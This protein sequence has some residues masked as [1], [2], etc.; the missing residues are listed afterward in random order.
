MKTK[1]LIR[2]LIFLVLVALLWLYSYLGLGMLVLAYFFFGNKI[3]F[4]ITLTIYLTV[5][6]LDQATKNRQ[7]G[8]CH[9]FGKNVIIPKEEDKREEVKYYTGKATDI[10]EGDNLLQIFDKVEKAEK[11][12]KKVSVTEGSSQMYQGAVN[13]VDKTG[14]RDD[15]VSDDD[16]SDY[17]YDE[18]LKTFD[19]KAKPKPLDSE[20][21]ESLDYLNKRG[22]WADG[23]NKSL[24]ASYSVIDIR[25]GDVI[26]K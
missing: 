26:K 9:K 16:S 14:N 21:E 25:T 17:L 20:I 3:T 18:V 24:P 12:N 7:L 15:E 6:L 2:I 23:T 19:P 8:F 4:V 13:K 11:K 1:E 5:L 10:K 22:A